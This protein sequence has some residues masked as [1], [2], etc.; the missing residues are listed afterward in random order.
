MNPVLF[1]F[2]TPVRLGLR[3]AFLTA[4][5]GGLMGGLM[6]CGGSRG[7]LGAGE[8]PGSAV[9][10]LGAE[11]TLLFMGNSHTASHQLPAMV[12][13][14]LRAARPGKSVE[15]VV[16]P[17]SMLLNARGSHSPSLG[18]IA[19]R[20]WTHV[21]LQAQDYS[22]SGLFTYP[23]TG[24]EKL[25]QLA[26]AQGSQTVLFAE[27]PRRGI[28]ESGRIFDT[29]ANIAQVQPA[30]LPPVP[31]AFDLAVTR[32]PS[33][34][35][36]DADGNHSG[37]AGAFLA[38]VILFSAMDDTPPAGLPA[39]VDIGVDALTQSQLKAVA[40]DTIKLHSPKRYCAKA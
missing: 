23:T 9:M 27:W 38:A 32:H 19:S 12:A 40:A 4:L 37:P 1:S 5:M 25:V 11:T 26:N 18:L 2:L 28:D 13:G 33:L 7:D 14:L 17:H 10:G 6:G 15:V 22:S 3:R 31:Q 36:W 34:S 20:R 8:A 35:L 29:Y 24:A 39:L 21:V 30:C 16:S